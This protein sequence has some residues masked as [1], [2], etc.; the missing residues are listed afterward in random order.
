MANNKKAQQVRLSPGKM[1]SSVFSFVARTHEKG[2]VLLDIQK[3][4]GKRRL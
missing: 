4:Q 2:L 3:S 1:M